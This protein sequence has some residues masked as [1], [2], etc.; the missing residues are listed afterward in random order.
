MSVLKEEQRSC[1]NREPLKDKVIVQDGYHPVFYDGFGNPC[2]T[3]KYITIDDPMTKDCK[4]SIGYGNDPK[5]AGCRWNQYQDAETVR[6]TD[7]G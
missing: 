1:Y 7:A 2:I 4:Y 3:P 5:C 6:I